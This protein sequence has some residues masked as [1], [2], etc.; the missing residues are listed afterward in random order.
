MND[1]AELE[2]ARQR[3]ANARMRLSGTLGVLQDRLAPRVLANEAWGNVRDQGTRV[4]DDTQSFARERPG[5]AA[6]ALGLGLAIA[7][8]RPLARMALGLV[9]GKRGRRGRPK[10]AKGDVP[11]ADRPSTQEEMAG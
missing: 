4:A 8:R 11:M 2:A 6:S 9:T 3:A 5:A 1:E 7:L 10:Y